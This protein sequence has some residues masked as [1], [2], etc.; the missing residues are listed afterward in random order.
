M[1]FV[2]P[3]PPEVLFSL[4]SPPSPHHHHWSIPPFYTGT[5]LCHWDR[6]KIT[7]QVPSRPADNIV[8][9]GTIFT[10][11]VAFCCS[12]LSD[13]P[14]R[15]DFN[16]VHYNVGDTWNPFLLPSGYFRCIKCACKLVGIPC[17]C[18]KYVKGDE[19]TEIILISL[20]DLLGKTFAGMTV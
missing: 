1:G 17:R 4:F 11:F 16:G 18:E 19:S 2:L 9:K 3:L 8:E 15:C 7:F 13:P 12:P 14:K 20:V 10:D 6:R 5:C